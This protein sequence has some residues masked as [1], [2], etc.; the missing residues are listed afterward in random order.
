[1][2][3][4]IKSDQDLV[5]YVERCIALAHVECQLGQALVS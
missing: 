3:K 2:S 5:N 1:M 4:R